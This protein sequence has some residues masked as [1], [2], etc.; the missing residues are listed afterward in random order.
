MKVRAQIGKVLNLAHIT[1]Q[2]SDFQAVVMVDVYMQRGD[3]QIVMMVLGGDNPA[4]QIAFLMLI[5]IS[6]HRKTLNA[7]FLRCLLRQG[8]AQNIADGFGAVIVASALAQAFQRF[9]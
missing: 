5:D 7:V 6:Q 8:V 2:Y 9:Q 3:G 4:G 1:L